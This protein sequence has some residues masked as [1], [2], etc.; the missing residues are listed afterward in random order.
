MGV[1][2]LL[3]DGGAVFEVKDDVKAGSELS[4]ERERFFHEAGLAAVVDHHREKG[5]AA[6]R[7]KEEQSRIHLGR[8]IHGMRPY[9]NAP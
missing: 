9:G 4:L 8:S 7:A 3:T 1:F 5:W 2:V 6:C